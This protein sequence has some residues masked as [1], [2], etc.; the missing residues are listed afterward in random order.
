MGGDNGGQNNTTTSYNYQFSPELM[1][2]A[3]KML[4]YGEEAAFGEPY[5]PYTGQRVADFTALQNQAFGNIGGMG[6]S[7]YTGQAANLANQVAGNQ[8][9]GANVNQ[10]MN[11]YVSTMQQDAI[12]NYSKQLPSLGAG[13]AKVG[14]LGGS[15]NAIM[16][17]EGQRGLQQQLQGIRANAFESARDQFNKTQANQ[18]AAA[19]ALG[20]LGMQE[21][22]QNAGINQAM[23]NAGALQQA[24]NQTNLNNSYNQ[25]MEEKNYPWQ[26]LMNFNAL[27]RGAPLNNVTANTTTPGISTP[28]QLLGMGVGY[29]GLSNAM[30]GGST[31]PSG[32]KP[33]KKGGSV[34]DI[35]SYKDGGIVSLAG[36]GNPP[37]EKMGAINAS[38]NQK[39]QSMPPQQAAAQVQQN[40]QAMPDSVDWQN[41]F[42]LYNYTK[43]HPT[44]P[45]P[46]KSDTVVVQMAR[47]I[48]AQADAKKAAEMKQAQQIQRQQMA[49]QQQQQ[50]QQAQQQMAMQQQQQPQ[51]GIAGLPTPNVGQNYTP[52]G[53]TAQPQEASDQQAPQVNA[54]SGGGISDLRADNVGKHYADG[55]IV[56]F[57]DGGDVKR[58]AGPEGSLVDTSSAP[59]LAAEV[60]EATYLNNPEMAQRLAAQAEAAAAQGSTE[61]QGWLG[62]NWARLTNAGAKV[63]PQWANKAVSLE[64][65]PGTLTKYGTKVANVGKASVLPYL[66]TEG[67]G[68]I[69]DLGKVGFN[70]AT[71]RQRPMDVPSQ[72]DINRYYGV[73]DKPGVDDTSFLGD[74]GRS[75]LALLQDVTPFMGG[76]WEE[77]RDKEAERQAKAQQTTT[78]PP[79]APPAPTAPTD[80]LKYFNTSAPTTSSIGGGRSGSGGISSLAYPEL[81]PLPNLMEGVEQPEKVED[82][83][84][85]TMDLRKKYGIGDATSNFLKYLDSREAELA[86]DQKFNRG[87]ALANAGFKMLSTPGQFAQSLGAGGMQYAQD[88]MALKKEENAAKLGIYQARMQAEN[89]IEQGK[90]SAIES[91][92]AQHERQL[93]RYR[94]AVTAQADLVEKRNANVTSRIQAI[95]TANYQNRMADI[96][97]GELDI[98]KAKAVREEQLAQLDS[99]ILRAFKAGD[100]PALDKLITLKS[101]LA[102]AQ[103]GLGMRLDSAARTKLAGDAEFTRQYNIYINPKATSEQ[104]TIALQAMRARTGVLGLPASLVDDIVGTNRGGMTF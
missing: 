86:G 87:M 93:D 56:A 47:Q 79:P 98:A 31:S 22:T 45:E 42:A 30:S 84:Q 27:L 65:L 91:G 59:W 97:G 57:E 94:T 16:E 103:S 76:P 69:T 58:Y 90:A 26:Q 49:M 82:L 60:E 62:R 14:G 66:A 89:A 23:M 104:R 33:A 73:E 32:T 7:G 10:F 71:G 81:S 72:A 19:G 6:V 99:A 51:Q 34:E 18:L 9:T 75:G 61:A 38:M 83:V 8:F 40:V 70:A 64:S 63:S 15:R 44:A 1:P 35:K 96:A 55:G 3:T 24:Q 85:K 50:A 4:G 20:N 92:M 25:F 11:P 102:E 29:A 88:M 53:I 39:S 5:K 67:A 36:G 48:A 37:V 95:G 28:A 52:A 12:R 2:Y 74:V 77:A 21:Y 78:T 68:Y 43:N 17:A 54:A 41:A 101:Q 13:A 100:Q 46:P 80:I